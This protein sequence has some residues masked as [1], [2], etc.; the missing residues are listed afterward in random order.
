MEIVVNTQHK[1]QKLKTHHLI[2]VLDRTT[3]YESRRSG[4]LFYNMPLVLIWFK[5]LI[6]F[7]QILSN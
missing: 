7:N 3:T 4:V 1:T 5:D 2:V 6:E